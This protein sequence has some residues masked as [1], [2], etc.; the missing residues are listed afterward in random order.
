MVAC[1]ASVLNACFDGR[2][3][4]KDL[5]IVGVDGVGCN[6]LVRMLLLGGSGY[7]SCV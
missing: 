6:A 5:R 2:V 1:I 7:W 3:T 4:V